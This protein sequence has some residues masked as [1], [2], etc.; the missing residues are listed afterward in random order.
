M[1]GLDSDEFKL[2][3][4]VREIVRKD[5]NP[6]YNRRCPQLQ[7]GLTKMGTAHFKK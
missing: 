5:V 3:W 2:V 7:S 6:A 4:S 1:V